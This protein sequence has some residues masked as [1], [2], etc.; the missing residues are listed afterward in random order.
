MKD[1]A[2]ECA[3]S[4]PAG[5]RG[6]KPRV[7]GQITIAIKENKVTVTGSTM[8]LRDVTGDVD[9]TKQCIE[10]KALAVTNAVALMRSGDLPR[11]PWLVV[12]PVT[13]TAPHGLRNECSNTLSAA[14]SIPS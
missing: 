1:I 10:Q 14:G 9:A 11:T 7:E 6:T 8:Q 4:L 12:G 13:I 5:A 2:L 3:K